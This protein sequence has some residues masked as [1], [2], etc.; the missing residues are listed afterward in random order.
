M[1]RRQTWAVFASSILA[2]CQTKP[3]AFEISFQA[4]QVIFLLEARSWSG[5]LLLAE[6]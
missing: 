2:E 5:E 3:P 1:Y 6:G 4:A